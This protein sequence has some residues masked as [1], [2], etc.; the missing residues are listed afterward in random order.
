M[1]ASV[2]ELF[3]AARA[4]LGPVKFLVNNAA[5]LHVAAVTE[6]GV[7]AFDEV[8]VVSARCAPMPSSRGRGHQDAAPGRPAPRH[9][10]EWRAY[11]SP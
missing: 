5:T 3:R 7:D 4:A 1:E 6:L 8:M 11:A 10:N 2:V 9:S